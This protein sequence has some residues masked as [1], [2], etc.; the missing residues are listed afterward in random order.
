MNQRKIIFEHRD[1]LDQ[2]D[3][4]KAKQAVCALKGNCKDEAFWLTCPARLEKE[5]CESGLKEKSESLQQLNNRVI[6]HIE[7]KALQSRI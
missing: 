1:A 7:G 6:A 4:A 5:R 2:F 3:E